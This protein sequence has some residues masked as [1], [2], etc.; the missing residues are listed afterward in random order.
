MEKNPQT[1]PTLH[2]APP[3]RIGN[4]KRVAKV[5]ILLGTTNVGKTVTAALPEIFCSPSVIFP[6]NIWWHQQ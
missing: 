3:F 4:R 1:F 5:Q 6:K 2:L